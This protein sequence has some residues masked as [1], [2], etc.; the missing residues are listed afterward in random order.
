MWEALQSFLAAYGFWII[1]GLLFLVMM[2][3][4]GGGGCGMGRTH[5]AGRAPSRQVDE[6][7]RPDT[8]EP[9]TGSAGRTGGCH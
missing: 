1:L 6:A 9:T 7:S 8:S 3:S 2:R 4:H 5:N